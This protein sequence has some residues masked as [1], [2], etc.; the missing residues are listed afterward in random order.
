MARLGEVER[1][2]ALLREVVADRARVLGEEH[3]D[4]R[5][6]RAELDGLLSG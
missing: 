1:A 4:T 5:G 6:T 3:R 2:V